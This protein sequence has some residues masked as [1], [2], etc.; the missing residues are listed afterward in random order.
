MEKVNHQLIYLI[1][2]F[3]NILGSYVIQKDVIVDGLWAF[4]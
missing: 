1:K 4:K 2:L 3:P